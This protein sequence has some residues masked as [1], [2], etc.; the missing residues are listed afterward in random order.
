MTLRMAD[1]IVAANLPTGMD[2]YAGYVDGNWVDYPDVIGLPAEH[3]LSITTQ[4]KNDAEC[5]DIESGDATAADAPGFVDNRHGSGFPFPKLYS[6]ISNMGAVTGAMGARPRS[7]Y[8]LWS[9]HYDP[10][11]GAHICGPDT[12]DYFGGRTTPQCDGTQWTDHGDWDE[13]LLADDFFGPVVAPSPPTPELVPPPQIIATT[14][15][16]EV[17][18]MEKVLVNIPLGADGSGWTPGPIKLLDGT[19]PPFSRV[20]GQP[21]LNPGNRQL[22]QKPTPGTA[23]CNSAWGGIYLEVNGGPPNTTVGV[24]LFLMD[25]PAGA[26]P[27]AASVPAPSAA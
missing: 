15:D 23:C 12:C 24:Y 3:F 6:S 14:P 7:S 18:N 22:G 5:L 9:A 4:A 2:A 19:I 10:Q 16:P 11:F 25:A 27:T 1:S 13:S 26:E 21:M 8:K 20:W 17:D